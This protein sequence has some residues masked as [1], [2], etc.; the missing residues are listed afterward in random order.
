MQLHRD[1]YFEQALEAYGHVLV[2]IGRDDAVEAAMR[3]ASGTLAPKQQN[4]Q[5]TRRPWT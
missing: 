1:G 4:T 2:A 5:V 3:R